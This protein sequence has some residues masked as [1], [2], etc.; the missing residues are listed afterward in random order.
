MIPFSYTTNTQIQPNAHKYEHAQEH[1]WKHSS[2]HAHTHTH[3]HT[4]ISTHTH[5]SLSDYAVCR[6]N[7]SSD[8]SNVS[9]YPS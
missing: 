7:T 9:E 8:H 4:H 5:D 2:K 3:T 1:T 6:N